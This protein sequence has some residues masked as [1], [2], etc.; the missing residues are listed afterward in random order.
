LNR[1]QGKVAII[2]GGTGGIAKTMALVGPGGLL[3]IAGSKRSSAIQ[4]SGIR[5]LPRCF[6]LAVKDHASWYFR[7][8]TPES[9][10]IGGG[11]GRAHDKFVKRGLAVVN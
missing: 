7:V 1:L 9:I 3:A 8:Q 4:F 10:F 6:K 2:T 11:I 5:P